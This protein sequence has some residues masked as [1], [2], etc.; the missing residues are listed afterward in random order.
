MGS[1]QLPSEDPTLNHIHC[2]IRDKAAV[3]QRT[4]VTKDFEESAPSA[5]VTLAERP[6]QIENR[7]SEVSSGSRGRAQE[8][9]QVRVNKDEPTVQ[10]N[11]RDCE[12]RSWEPRCLERYSI[13]AATKAEISAPLATPSLFMSAQVQLGP[14]AS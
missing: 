4:V 5:W 6:R 11:Q 3:P 13:I 9:R 10:Q 8:P 14:A 2:E 7:H 12:I 1:A